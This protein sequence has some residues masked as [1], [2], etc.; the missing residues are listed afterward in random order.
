M[1]RIARV[2][3][4]K[5]PYHITQR[6]N[7]REKVFF[8]DKDYR[9]YL[10]WLEQYSKKS[11]LEVYAY[12]LMSNHV[13]IV[14]A[15]RG[16]GTLTAV[17]RPLHMRYAQWIN[18]RRGWNGHLWQGRFFSSALDESYLW[19]AVRYVERNPVRARIVGFAENYEWSSAAAH[20]GK[21][22]D[23]LLSAELPLIGEIENWSQWLREEEDGDA[24]EVLRRN[25]Q[26]GIPCGSEEFI[27]GLE[28]LL[29]RFLRFRPPWRPK[30]R[31]DVAQ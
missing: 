17:L 8:R 7:R 27:A 1:P 13:H 25:T 30:K 10:E 9:Q 19:T 3:V 16:E 24:V 21:R 28:S 18:K 22:K 29:K 20:C 4:E 12:C 2:I 31:S 5:I 14:G 11:G 23:S 26:K 15:P 6:G